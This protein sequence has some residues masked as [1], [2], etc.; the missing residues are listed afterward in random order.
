[1]N[2]F[3]FCKQSTLEVEIYWKLNI[4]RPRRFKYDVDSES[5]WSHA[6]HIVLDQLVS[7]ADGAI[8]NELT[9]RQKSG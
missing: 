8:F 9:N 6:K 1:M 3:S 7:A 4:G 5:F 2:E